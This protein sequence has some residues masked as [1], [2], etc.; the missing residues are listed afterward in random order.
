MGKIIRYL[1]LFLILLFTFVMRHELFHMQLTNSFYSYYQAMEYTV[2]EDEMDSFIKM[3]HQEEEKWNCS[4]FW[5]VIENNS[6]L[7]QKIYIYSDSKIIQKE[8]SKKHIYEGEYESFFSGSSSVTYK[9]SS[10]CRFDDFDSSGFLISTGNENINHE[11]YSRLSNYFTL[12]YPR[13]YQSD[14]KDMVIIIWTLSA[15]GIIILCGNDVLRQKKE[16]VVRG[17]YGENVKWLVVK[18]A[19]VNF[20]VFH[21]IYICA[22]KIVFF[23][24]K[25]DYYPQI[26][27][28]LFEAG[29]VLGSL[30]Y[31][32]LLKL[33]VKQ[34]IANGNE[35]KSYIIFLRALKCV[36]Y[37]IVFF[38]LSTNISSAG[39][40]LGGFSSNELYDSYQNANFIYLKNS[41]DTYNSYMV[42]SSKTQRTLDIWKDL[43]INEIDSLRPVLSLK[44]AKEYS[45]YLILNE[46]AGPLISDL[47]KYIDSECKDEVY[48]LYGKF[49]QLDQELVDSIIN[50]YFIDKEIQI[51]FV[52]Y[53]DRISVS[54]FDMDE[55]SGYGDSRNPVIIYCPDTSALN[56]DRIA[57]HQNVIYDISKDDYG[58]IANKY[59]FME[60]KV[61]SE[62]TNVGEYIEYK[63][64]FLNRM[65]KFLSSLCTIILLLDWFIMFSIINLEYKKNGMDYA[66]KKILGYGIIKK[67]RSQ[68]IQNVIPNIVF[69]VILCVLGEVSNLYSAKTGI[70]VTSIMIG[71]EIAV[72]LFFITK[73]ERNSVS[74]ILKGGCL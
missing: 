71:M 37:I 61:E 4:M 10:E 31:L 22:K 38:S 6:R 73:M 49:S 40:I 47:L 36:A 64:N 34:V 68:I 28:I 45:D 30:L 72:L 35:D 56:V 50:F 65:I 44:V 14:E 32:G 15:L 26:A 58:E 20:L 1:S 16:I 46:N 27:F 5:I 57:E 66:V 67:N 62:I 33:D 43:Y 23:S 25:A 29:C 12:S 9:K 52:P 7:H 24:S 70:T 55:L 74:K 18:R 41:R 39:H 42:N 60:K 17:I 3:I 59:Q 54:Y 21:M 11:V 53:K 51:N 69:S 2:S 19:M 63:K 8:L 13:F 48:V